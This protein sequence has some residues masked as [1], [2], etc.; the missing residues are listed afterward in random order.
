MMKILFEKLDK[1][2]SELDKR[3]YSELSDYERGIKDILD[4]LNIK[5]SDNNEN[6]FYNYI[7]NEI[8]RH[9]DFYYKYYYQIDY[10]DK[11]GIATYIKTYEDT[12][13]SQALYELNT[14]NAANKCINDTTRY[15]LDKHRY[16]VDTNLRVI[17]HSD[18]IIEK[19]IKDEYN[20]LN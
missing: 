12:E 19:D 15:V 11:D 5:I 7:M 6:E 18:E 13:R 17:D 20:E 16:K 14:L 3:L 9:H 2:Y 1:I 4:L 10:V 8:K